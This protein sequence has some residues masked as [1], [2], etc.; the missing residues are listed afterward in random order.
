MKLL[1]KGRGGYLQLPNPQFQKQKQNPFP[2]PPT[3]KTSL[4]SS[5]TKYTSTHN[6]YNWANKRSSETQGG[7]KRKKEKKTKLCLG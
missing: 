7:K 2:S 5:P 3:K 6:L 4:S 1:S